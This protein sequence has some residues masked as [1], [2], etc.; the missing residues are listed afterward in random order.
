MSKKTA[1]VVC[2]GRGTYNKP[3]LGYLGRHHGERREMRA[4]FEAERARLSQ[5]GLQSL[6]G[7]ERYSV[8]TH[9]RGDNASLLI[10]ACAYGD[11]QAIDR[12][13]FD[14]VAVTGNSMGWYI[15]L[16]CAGA[17]SMADGARIVNTMGTIMQENLIGGQIVYPL[18]DEDWREVPGRRAEITAHMTAV[19]AKLDHQVYVS[20]EL[21]GML[22]LAGNNK[23]LKA[24][25]ATLPVIDRFPLNLANHAAFHTEL[26]ASNSKRGLETLSA[27]MFSQPDVPLI[28]GRGAIWQR[29]ATDTQALHQYTFGHQVTESYDFTRAVEVG[30][31]EFAPDCVIVLGPGTTLGGAVAQSL[32]GIDWQGLGSKVD[33][34]LRQESDPYLLAMGRED[35]RLRVV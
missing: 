34:S 18:L 24:L 8:A 12:S 21:G 35:Q 9:T 31:R 33:F 29:G 13:K 17:V 32:I 20:I 2:P 15:A 5:P 26:Q 16:A 3:E 7:A 23:G 25:T 14:V 4:T 30:A 28:D 1:L 11:F 22:V 6:D 27:D 10:H 19:N